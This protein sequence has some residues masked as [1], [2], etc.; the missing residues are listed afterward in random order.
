MSNTRP[1]DSSSCT[2]PTAHF[3]HNATAR[4][5]PFRF[6]FISDSAVA[7]TTVGRPGAGQR[8]LQQREAKWDSLA[9]TRDR[10]SRSTGEV[11]GLTDY[12]VSP[13]FS[14]TLAWDAL[15]DTIA[16]STGDFAIDV[17]APG[18]SRI[19]LS[20]DTVRRTTTPALAAREVGEGQTVQIIGRKPCL[21]PAEMILEVAEI[22]EEVP[23]Y[24]AITLAPNGF[25]WATRDMLIDEPAVADLYHM[26]HGFLRTVPLGSARPVAFLGPRLLVSVETD[27]DDVPRV[28]AYHVPESLLALP[29]GSASFVG[30]P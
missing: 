19:T 26:D 25:V 2:H 1:S 6:R 9:A 20:R 27:A 28:V 17:L 15:G 16:F 18:A 22:A 3:A 24:E 11:C 29:T 5:H 10:E 23:A 30:D 12:P 7:G 4:G 14:E 13:I 21:V 8:L